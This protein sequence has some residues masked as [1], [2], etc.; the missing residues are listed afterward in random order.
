MLL[1]GP[2]ITVQ[3][4]I[5]IESKLRQCLQT[6]RQNDRSD[7][8]I[9]GTD[10]YCSSQARP[11]VTSACLVMRAPS[12]RTLHCSGQSQLCYASVSETDRVDSQ[13]LD[14]TVL[15]ITFYHAHRTQFNAEHGTFIKRTGEV[16]DNYTIGEQNHNNNNR[17]LI[18][19][20]AYNR[21][22]AYIQVAHEQQSLL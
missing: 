9:N 11:K 4:F 15:Q 20:S 8:I 1:F 5:K 6:D 7:F 18:T 2:R 21:A 3:N 17:L 14:K 12:L 22:D 16:I 19:S 13:T 10:N